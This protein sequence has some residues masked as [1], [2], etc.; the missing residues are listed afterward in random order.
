VCATTRIKGAR[1]LQ[2]GL[3]FA[4]ALFE[5][6][7]M[8]CIGMYFLVQKYEIPAFQVICQLVQAYR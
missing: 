5:D 6:V 4:L 1:I 2:A 3:G 8:L 7:P